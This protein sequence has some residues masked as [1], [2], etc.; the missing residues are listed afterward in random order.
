MAFT[1]TKYKEYLPTWDFEE[2]LYIDIFF[3]NY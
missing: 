1:L 2:D 3:F